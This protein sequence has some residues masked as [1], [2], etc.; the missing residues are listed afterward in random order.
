MNELHIPLT[1]A[2]GQFL[3]N[4]LANTLKDLSIEEHRTRT[5]TFRQSVTEQKDLAK[6]VLDKVKN[7]LAPALTA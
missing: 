6:V 3:E 7:A 2:E 4:L 5:P 1:T